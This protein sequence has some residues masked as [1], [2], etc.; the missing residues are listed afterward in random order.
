[1]DR[2]SIVIAAGGS[3]GHVIPAQILAEKLIAK[4]CAIT[5]LGHGLL[6]NRFIHRLEQM[7]IEDIPS[8]APSLKQ[9][10]RFGLETTKGCLKALRV[11]KQA[12]PVLVVGFGSFHSFPVLAAAQLLNIP[13]VLYESNTKMGKV[14]AL[15]AKKAALLAS[16]FEV[17]KGHANFAHVEPLIKLDPVAFDKQIALEGYGLETEKKTLLVMGGSQGS[18]F[19]NLT[20][21][22]S[23]L[24]ELD[25][26]IW[27]VIHLVGYKDSAEKVLKRYE[28]SGFRAH[29]QP[30]EKHIDRAYSAADI[31]LCRGG[32]TTLLELSRRKVPA[33]L[34]PYPHSKDEHQKHNSENY[35][36]THPGK[37]IEEKHWK[38]RQLS[39]A[40]EELLQLD[41]GSSRL[42]DRNIQQPLE[43][44]IL[45]LCTPR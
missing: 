25:P 29:V 28:A 20:L 3:G 18:R 26:R 37:L 39:E 22:E 43:E 32:A 11:L 31:V 44:K 23:I 16:P 35:L 24:S 14:I 21:L 30:F 13:I 7:R 34:I 45:A 5:L 27:Q 17:F 8:Y 10:F 38:S 12:K 40:V 2:V 1:M 41:P 36:K 9:A 15:F 42:A 6:E 33:L 19:F 4:G